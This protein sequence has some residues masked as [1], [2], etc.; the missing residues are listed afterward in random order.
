MVG[1]CMRVGSGAICLSAF[2]LAETNA[3]VPVFSCLVQR[4]NFR[5]RTCGVQTSKNTTLHVLETHG[6]VLVGRLKCAL[7]CFRRLPH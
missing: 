4:M 2:A 3:W 6:L 5:I 7:I 1:V